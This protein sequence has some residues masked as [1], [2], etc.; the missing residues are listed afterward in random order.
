LNNII[1]GI[2]RSMMLYGRADDYPAERAKCGKMA[3]AEAGGRESSTF[4][5]RPLS[6]PAAAFR[7]SPDAGSHARVKLIHQIGRQAMAVSVVILDI[8]RAIGVPGKPGVQV[9]YIVQICYISVR[10]HE[11][12]GK[13]Y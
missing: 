8:H 4:P 3:P 7:A 5:F 9:D 13:L 11:N 1:H 2:F 12:R 10:I 6:P